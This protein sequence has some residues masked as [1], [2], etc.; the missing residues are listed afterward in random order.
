MNIVATTRARIRQAGAS[1]GNQL[2]ALFFVGMIG[3]VLITGYG[4]YYTSQSILKEKLTDASKQTIAQASEKLDLVYG[5]YDEK[6]EQTAI[7]NLFLKDVRDYLNPDV[8]PA[9]RALAKVKIQTK[10]N[11]LVG[12]DDSLVS[13]QLYGADG[14]WLA[15]GRQPALAQDVASE[16]W[17]AGIRSNNGQ[18]LWLETASRG[19]SGSGD[20]GGEAAVGLARALG[21]QGAG[22][23]LGALL[24]EIKLDAIGS[25]LNAVRIGDGGVKLVASERGT[26]IYDSANGDGNA[27]AMIGAILGGA[28]NADSGIAYVRDGDGVEQALVYAKSARNG[29]YTLAYV[30][31]NQ[32]L[33]ET[34][35]I[36]HNT[37]VIAGLSMLLAVV[38]GWWMARRFGRPLIR[39]KELMQ[40]GE[41]GD[42]QVRMASSRKDEIGQL[43]ASFNG[44]MEQITRFVR[45]S[46]DSA[47]EV[48]AT[49][50]ELLQASRSTDD[51]ASRMTRA[52]RE[53]AAG[54]AELSAET[55][56]VS[57]MASETTARMGTVI[58]HSA[59]ME[60]EATELIGVGLQGQALMRRLRGHTA[61][62][63][64]KTRLMA[65]GVEK[66]KA[67]NQSVKLVMNKLQELANRTN[68]LALNASIEAHRAGAAG[69]GFKVVADEIRKLAEQSRTTIDGV[70]DMTNEM[71][72]D[73]DRAARHMEETSPILAKQSDL[74]LGTDDI[75]RQVQE[76]Q[77]GF[78]ANLS[79]MAEV[80]QNMER[81]QLRLAS[82]MEN[83]SAIS[84]QSYATSVEVAAQGDLQLQISSRLL[85]LSEQMA[86]MSEGLR[87]DLSRFTF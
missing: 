40:A 30:P 23:F 62:V 47:R 29:W 35:S 11:E 32:L 37:L 54:S 14:Q 33:R 25:E 53:I 71:L 38:M 34:R 7:N 44:M 60:Q 73:I 72:E 5:Q 68:I 75:F 83:V 24:Y 21:N 87:K 79:A 42:L 43:S 16:P 59:R 78:L 13:V 45:K 48:L 55:E 66:L 18:A 2:F 27:A 12:V 82:A 36:W 77:N 4:S 81:S 76:R 58:E 8:L 15:A 51:S 39:L 61:E 69:A 6:T 17:F 22:E 31:V 84:E 86:D 20:D 28:A 65:D 85:R 26:L 41:N 52:N 10:L 3:F 64:T 56:K 67:G 70:R 63:E 74:V 1:V 46:S 57:G 9:D 49:S 19:Y 80:L 50:E